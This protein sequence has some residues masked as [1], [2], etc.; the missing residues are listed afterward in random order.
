MIRDSL[1]IGQL[2][3]GNEL[4]RLMHNLADK[5]INNLTS[6]LAKYDGNDLFSK[7]LMFIRQLDEFINIYYE[8]LPEDKNQF[9][10]TPLEEHSID[11]L[12]NWLKNYF[13]KET[14]LRVRLLIGAYIS[15]ALYVH[16]GGL[17]TILNYKNVGQL[18][19][20]C[21][22]RRL[23]YISLLHMIPK[24]SFGEE[25]VKNNV[26]EDIW[27]CVDFGM[28]P[29][30]S[31]FHS[32]IQSR[33]L[34]NYEAVCCENGLSFNHEYSQLE[35]CSLE[36][37][38]M[39]D[40]DLLYYNPVV[41]DKIFAEKDSFSLYSKKELDA[42]YTNDALYYEKYNLAD[43]DVYKSLGCLIADV[44]PFFIDDYRIEIPSSCFENLEAKYKKFSLTCNS[45]S[46]YD[47]MN[48]RVAFIKFGD[49]YFSNYYFLI[50]YYK[51]TVYQTLRHNRTFQIDSGFLFEKKV[52]EDLM[53]HGFTVKENCKRIEHK[54][55]DVVCVKN[56]CIYNFQC[57][58]N[59]IN[60]QD[61]DTN[62]INVVSRYHK[63]LSRYYD[64]A[65][66][67]EYSREHLLKQ[68]FGIDKVKHYVISR[69]PVITENQDVISFNVLQDYLKNGI[70]E[71]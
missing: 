11:N 6:Y 24:Y 22:Q 48:T 33:C 21:Q 13:E 47:L 58:N 57:K 46:V 14:I 39:T 30:T 1:Y 34:S 25:L 66:K 70:L 40:V 62:K 65:L 16:I 35:N 71:W 9:C 52:I 42:V 49:T 31:S 2:F 3:R 12:C 36:P 7:W 17:S 59:Y 23:H 45:N 54:E 32:I 5:K 15:T 43:N 44:K 67:K 10:Q 38:R 4:E 8:L 18:L 29:I 50:R 53:K 26:I 55:F 68:K 41:R 51:N 64:K 19:Q 20:F 63:M 27:G 37:L 69:Y 60:V 56:G 28:I 61:I